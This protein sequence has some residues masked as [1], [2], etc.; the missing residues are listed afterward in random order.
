MCLAIYKPANI[1]PDWHRLENGMCFNSDGAGFAVAVDGQLIVEKGFFKFS[2]F[3][4]AL[5]PFG[6]HPMIIH[7]RLATHGGKNKRNC[8][9]FALADFGGP[10]DHEPVAVIHNG[11]FYQAAND[12]KNWSDTWHV[13]RDVLHP[14]WLSDPSL[15]YKPE[16]IA[17]GDGF[18]GMSNKLVFLNSKG[19][20]SIWG[21]SNGH[22]DS[23]C[24]W[25]NRSY[26][27]YRVADPRWSPKGKSV[28][29][30]YCTSSGVHDDSDRYYREW[31]KKYDEEKKEGKWKDYSDA[32]LEE[33]AIG[34][35]DSV[36]NLDLELDRRS[37]IIANELRDIGTTD[38]EIEKIYLEDGQ[39]GLL[40]ELASV[41]QL[42]VTDVERH[43]D[44]RMREDDEDYSELTPVVWDADTN[45]YVAIDQH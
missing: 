17:L 16:V 19:E 20:F 12:D 15:F 34:S 32:E 38:R 9:P 6:D 40:D 4:K 37:L 14:M 26:E 31:E 35:N 29:A 18:V 27:D 1:K 5:E 23:G 25:S 3:K 24:W 21:A 36:M 30:P 22:W 7:F 33:F 28:T 2:D 39:G 11:I 41:Y 43:V 8:H 44:S 10:D 13:C 45:E 42:S